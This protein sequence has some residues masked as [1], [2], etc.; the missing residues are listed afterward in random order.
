MKDMKPIEGV[1]L[2]LFLCPSSPADSQSPSLSAHHVCL[3]LVSGACAFT[4]FVLPPPS[5]FP[6]PRCPAF[7][8]STPVSC[9]LQLGTRMRRRR[10]R[11][12]GRA[13]PPFFRESLRLTA[14]SYADR[15]KHPGNPETARQYMTSLI[16]GNSGMLMPIALGDEHWVGPRAR[17]RKKSGEIP[18]RAGG[19]GEEGEEEFIQNRTRARRDSGRSGTSTLSRNTG[20]RRESAR[21]QQ[22]EGARARARMRKH[23]HTLS[24]TF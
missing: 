6:K 24:N 20:R 18:G 23:T 1:L 19:I 9:R 8:R 15:C 21:D 2:L 5:P 12:G 3:W 22:H 7:A 13:V 10:R 17:A 4:A 14:L 16:R 11:E